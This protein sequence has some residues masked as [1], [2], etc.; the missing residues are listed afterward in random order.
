M[1]L[2]HSRNKTSIL[3]SQA[4]TNALR[5]FRSY[6]SISFNRQEQLRLPRFNE[7]RY[8]NIHSR[9]DT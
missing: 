1:L 3:I 6:Y 2:T 7:P 8:L 4:Q 9:G 5:Y